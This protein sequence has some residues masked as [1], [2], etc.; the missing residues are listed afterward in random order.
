MAGWRI[1]LLPDPVPQS[2][3]SRVLHITSTLAG[4]S[5]DKNYPVSHNKKKLLFRR[6]QNKV[7]SCES[8][9]RTN[10]CGIER[11]QAEQAGCSHHTGTQPGAARGLLSGLLLLVLLLLSLLLLL[12]LLQTLPLLKLITRHP[13]PLPIPSPCRLPTPATVPHGAVVSLPSLL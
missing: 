4:E 12:F 8:S 5:N 6:K 7:F 2:G 9:E 10:G 1:Y 11:R 3:W 13:L